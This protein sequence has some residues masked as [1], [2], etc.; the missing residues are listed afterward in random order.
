MKQSEEEAQNIEQ[1]SLRTY[2]PPKEALQNVS[3]FSSTKVG[4]KDL[5]KNKVNSVFKEA[6]E[7]ILMSGGECRPSNNLEPKLKTRYTNIEENSTKLS[8]EQLNKVIN[9]ESNVNDTFSTNNNNIDVLTKFHKY[10]N[11]SK[12]KNT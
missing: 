12:F 10:S 1:D 9:K 3:D 11:Q 8:K 2:P 7:K 4:E 5:R 6:G